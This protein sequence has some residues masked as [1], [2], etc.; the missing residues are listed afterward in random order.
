MKQLMVFITW[1]DAA[2][3]QDPCKIFAY[4]EKEAYAIASKSFA[5]PF[6]RRIAVEGKLFAWD[7]VRPVTK[8]EIIAECLRRLTC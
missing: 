3:H 5:E 7:L 6:I 8:E 2:S 1:Y 4:T